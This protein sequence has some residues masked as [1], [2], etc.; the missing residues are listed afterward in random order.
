MSSHPVPAEAAPVAATTHPTERTASEARGAVTSRDGTAIGYRRFGTGPGLVLLH[1][2][3]SSSAHQ[4][5]LARALAG[6]FTVIVPDRRGRGLS[7]P[8]R[9]G[10]A[11][12]QGLDDVTAILD[13]TGATSVWGLS[14]GAILALEAARTMPRIRKVAAFEPP[15]LRD[16]DEAVRVLATYDDE[17]ARGRI[18]DA[19]VTA[20]RGA[21]MGPGWLRAMPKALTSRLVLAGMRQEAKG[22]AGDY[23]TMRDLAP[24]LHDDFAVVAAAS[25]D[26]DRYRSISADVLL[27]GGDRSPAFLKRALDHLA[28]VLPKARRVTLAGLGHDASWNRDRGGDPAPVAAELRAFFG[29]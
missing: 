2:S 24:T 5:E 6:A 15:L 23:P 17:M 10:D 25:G 29:R 28:T 18:G 20:M 22:Q 11:L 16:R 7:G 26:L 1:G 27:M 21:E 13:A 14:S 4:V 19:M 12:A 9:P 8:P 3:A